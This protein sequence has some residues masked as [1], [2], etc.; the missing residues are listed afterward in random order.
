VL[1]PYHALLFQFQ[2]D[3]QRFTILTNQ[4]ALGGK[5]LDLEIEQLKQAIDVKLAILEGMRG[6]EK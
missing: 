4:R 3:T 1:T 2:G 5:G 6:R